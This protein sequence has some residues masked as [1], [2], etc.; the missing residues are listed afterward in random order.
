MREVEKEKIEA[1]KASF[2]YNKMSSIKFFVKE[3]GSLFE[4]SQMSEPESFA[5]SEC[6]KSL[7]PDP[8]DQASWFDVDMCPFIS[9]GDEE[10]SYGLLQYF[11]QNPNPKNSSWGEMGIP[12][13]IPQSILDVLEGKTFVVK[14]IQYGMNP[15]A[16]KVEIVF[17]KVEKKNGVKASDLIS[18][19][20]QTQK[21]K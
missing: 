4:T 5:I 2:F 8:K 1:F 21:A 14:P 11:T 13:V 18:M 6:V 12:K 20:L 17:E 15:W 16:E 10:V 3:S 7:I 9:D 19:A